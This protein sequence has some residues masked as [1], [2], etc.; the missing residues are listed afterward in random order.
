MSV[1][2]TDEHK[3]PTFFVGLFVYGQGYNFLAYNLYRLKKLIDDNDF[4]YNIYFP[5]LLN[6]K[7]I[8]SA[9]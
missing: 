8:H 4:F 9:I 7:K 2:S 1:E 5:V 3:S 6:M